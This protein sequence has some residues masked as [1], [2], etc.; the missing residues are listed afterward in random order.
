MHCIP[1]K[2]VEQIIESGNDYVIAVKGNQPK[3]YR[4]LKAEF[5]QHLPQSIDDPI[6]QTRNRIT[7]RTVSVL[8]TRAGLDA[9]WHGVQRLI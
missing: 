7:R 6:E 9:T 5:E 1:K 2:T 3:L 4:T 8:E